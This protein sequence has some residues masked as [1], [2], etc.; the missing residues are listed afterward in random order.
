MQHVLEH[1]GRQ[2]DIYLNII[3]E[4]Y[5]ICHNGAT[6][7]IVV[8]HYRHQYFFDDPTHVRAVTPDGLQ[9]F[10]KKLN[11]EWIAGG[12]A[13]SP[14]GLYLDVD[15]ELI[16]TLYK[17]SQDWFRLHPETPVDVSLLIRESNLYNNLVE[18][19]DMQLTV[20]KPGC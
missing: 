7:R 20:I 17:P 2:T 8:P 16:S 10:S 4:I 18:E 11:Q 13:N 3:K 9:L 1:L 5:R 19:L 6:I 15:F 12:Y 14:L